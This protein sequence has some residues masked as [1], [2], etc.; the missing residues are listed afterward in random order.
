MANN[1]WICLRRDI[2]T[3]WLFNFDEPDKFM[4]W[5]DL[6]MSANHEDRKFM[7]KG[8]VVECKRGQVAMSQVTL[9]KR[10]KMSQ[11][12]LKRFLVLLKNDAMIDFETNDLTTII[13]ICNY[14][15]FQD[16]ERADGRPLERADGRGADDHS[17]DKQQLNNLTIK[18]NNLNTNTVNSM[19]L[20]ASVC[21][22]YRNL[23]MMQANPQHPDLLELIAGGSE[24]QEFVSAGSLAMDAGKGFAYA[25]GIVKNRKQEKLIESSRGQNEVSG[26]TRQTSTKKL[27]LVER[28][29]QD[30]QLAEQLERDGQVQREII[31]N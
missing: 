6:L 23:G 24:L 1:G 10:W 13:T 30:C 29:E 27:S 18:Q 16:N 5:C 7:I 8:R 19:S 31:V 11:N 15:K 12:K 21:V 26:T 28:A 9:Q 22:E 20:A 4:A 3:H 17:N 25:L 2:R 14:S